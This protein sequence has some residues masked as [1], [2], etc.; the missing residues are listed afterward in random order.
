MYNF[1]LS[2]NC[3]TITVPQKFTFSYQ[4]KLWLV[5]EK[6]NLGEIPSFELK[7]TDILIRILFTLGPK[8]YKS[9]GCLQANPVPNVNYIWCKHQKIVYIRNV[10]AYLK[11]SDI[12]GKE[13]IGFLYDFLMFKIQNIWYICILL[14]FWIFGL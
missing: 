10:F 9:V 13:I 12:N 8:I 3:S 2:S 4:T 11:G 14:K 1:I 5:I 6:K 7:S